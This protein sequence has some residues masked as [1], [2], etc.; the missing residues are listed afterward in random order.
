MPVDT[1]KKQ[2][3]LIH[4]ATAFSVYEDF[5]KYLKSAPIDDPLQ[6]EVRKSWKQGFKEE[7]SDEFEVYY[8]SMPNKQNA[9]YLEWKIWFERYFEFLRDGVVLIG[10]SQGGYFLVKYLSENTLPFTIRALYLLAAPFEA[11]D[12]KGED[13]GDFSFD[14]EKLSHISD[15]VSS[16]FIFHSTDDPIVP[17]D[18]A[19][20]Y[21]KALPH[22]KLVTFKDRGHFLVE[23][24][25]ELIE[26]VKHV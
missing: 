11:G 8:P 9:K 17:Y 3:L 13:G 5:L 18:H 10:H 24:L 26:S 19:R 22:A 14:P 6:E 15:Q 21:Q 2:I 7:L 12:F 16:V 1:I 23:A 25:P 20:K 4:G